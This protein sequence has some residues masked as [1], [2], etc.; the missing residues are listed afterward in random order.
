MPERTVVIGE[1]IGQEQLQRLRDAFPD[2]RFLLTPDK[3]EFLE[4]APQAEIIFTKGLSSEVV[5]AAEKL[6]WVQSGTAGI[7]WMLRAGLLDNDVTLTTASGVYGTT[8]AEL[9]LAM[10]LAF[11]SGVNRF[12]RAQRD[13]RYIRE[14]VVGDKFEL[15]GHSLC[16]IGLGDIGGTLAAKAQALGM[17]V[18]G[19]RRSD[20]SHPHAR[21]V[22]TN[23]QLTEAVT[24]ADHVAL[25]LPLTE[26]TRH[27]VDET[28]LR[29][30]KAGAYIYNVGRGAS[31][32]EEAMIRALQDGHLGGAGLDVTETEPPPKDSPLWEMENVILTQHSAGASP[33]NAERTTTLF[34]ENL[35]RY[36]NDEPLKNVVDKEAGY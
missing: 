10:M 31:I 2:I 8:I 11:G 26:A 1:D 16:V 28:V 18:V 7:G 15:E 4:A 34:M 33:Y 27:M 35:R 22:Y 20:R 5:D 30:M 17:D 12:I 3:D 36:L 14:E 25:C 6:R 13:K 32:D 19:V 23:D 9:I 29:A 21:R 24:D